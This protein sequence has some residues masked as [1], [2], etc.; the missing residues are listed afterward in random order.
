MR[1]S[2][3]S[4]RFAA[5]QFRRDARAGEL[6]L[7][8]TAL[9]IAVACVTAVG[10]FVDRVERGLEAQAATLLGADLV[11]RASH[12]LPETLSELAR[13]EGL[14]TA[15]LV[16]FRSVAI[17]D[18]R[19]QLVEVKAAGAGYPLRGRLEIADAPFAQG[20][21]TTS[22]PSPGEAWVAPRLLQAGV[23][24][25]ETIEL[26]AASF[27]ITRVLAFEPDRGGDLFSIAPR[28]LIPLADLPATRLLGQGAL[29]EYRLL[30]AGS[31]EDVARVRH[32]L[33]QHLAAGEKL[34]DVRESRPELRTALE[35]AGR[36]LG[37]A[38]L[39]SV[40]LAG[41]AV[42]TAARRF[43]TRH[44]DTAAIL[45][46]HGART[47]FVVR[48][49]AL[50]MLGLAVLG[51][52]LGI[53]LGVLLQW[54]LAA[55]L[56]RLFLAELPPP[57]WQP[58]IGGYLT[59]LILL[60]GFALPPLAALAR[61]PPLRILR[62]DLPVRP[63]SRGLTFLSL[64]LGLGL[65]LWWQI[66]DAQ[67]VLT[68][69][70]GTLATLGLLASCALVLVRL[71]QPLRTRAGF[72][73]RQGLAAIA[74]RPSASV[75][76]ISAIG[77]A[78]MVILLLSAVRSELFEQWQ[79]SLPP[80][81]PNHFLINIQ[82]DQLDDMRTFFAEHGLPEPRLY[83]M[84]RARLLR[85]GDRPVRAA[86]YTSLRARHLATR[87]FNLSWAGQPN[88]DNRIVAGRW[89]TAAEHGQ[90]LLSLEAGIARTLGIALNDTLTFRVNGREKTFTVT[91]LRE[92][93]WD[94]FR[95]N[96]FTVV[97][98]GILE[99][100]PASWVTSVHLDTAQRSLVAEL[101]ARFPNVT[102]LDVAALMQRV[103]ALLD[104]VA[105]AMELLFLFTLLAALLVLLSVI[106]TQQDEHR[107]ENALLRSLGVRRQRLLRAR[108]AE[109]L[110]LGAL[111][112]ILGGLAATLVAWILAVQIFR[113]PYAF[114]PAISLIGLT[115]GIVVVTAAGLFAA[116]RFLDE[117]PVATL[118]RLE[119]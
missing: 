77:L 70:G 46:A 39:L 32:R 72:A 95:V 6:N 64:L 41:V 19:P 69:L 116:R 96:F 22:L 84:V 104:R 37:L 73:W 60:L 2:L 25:G 82:S 58:A 63:V 91:S 62:R 38:A 4:L 119:S 40:L 35:R 23:R 45:R 56:A 7:L 110:V 51:G 75:I 54:G 42:A 113:F 14:R 100:E 107:F 26:G 99:T 80:D 71:L 90:P 108:M 92:V 88:P 8:T 50:E 109:H 53:L 24:P 112:G 81:A 59:A 102:V 33:A 115:L 20:Q 10:F 74:R 13:R 9:G 48:G 49:F 93:D 57:S 27:R 65:L 97:P 11:I 78:I 44:L 118:R 105:L 12:P 98:P 117:P 101:V 36:F 31:P 47:G 114:S 103:R 89:W 94:S 106:A 34:L 17:L 43:A 21:A 16:Q 30:L 79:R 66:R 111:A 3:A 1:A 61:V 68:V 29:A 76:Q 67:L 86:D 52:T 55:I 18:G 5:R 87:E 85:I 83:P 15:R 28:V